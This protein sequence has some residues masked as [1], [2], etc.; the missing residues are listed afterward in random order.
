[1]LAFLSSQSGAS[2]IWSV[3]SGAIHPTHFV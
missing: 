2:E 3:R 1:M